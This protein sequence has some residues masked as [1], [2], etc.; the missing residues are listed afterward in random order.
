VADKAWSHF[1]ALQFSAFVDSKEH[2]DLALAPF[3]GTISLIPNNIPALLVDV[4]VCFGLFFDM[5]GALRAYIPGP[6]RGMRTRR[7]P[8]VQ[9]RFLR[10][11]QGYF[12]PR[13]RRIQTTLP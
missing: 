2:S 12:L 13:L 7:F 5:F 8:S 9:R 4:F 10:G 1:S 3:S 11:G 6:Q